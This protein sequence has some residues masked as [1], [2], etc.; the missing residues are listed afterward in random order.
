MVATRSGLG[1]DDAK[2]CMFQDVFEAASSR[3]LPCLALPVTKAARE[4]TRNIFVAR[5]SSSPQKLV[6]NAAC[7]DLLDVHFAR[8]VSLYMFQTRQKPC[9]LHLRYAIS[10]MSSQDVKSVGLAVA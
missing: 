8:Q 1:V 10:N 9:V 3:R 2:R 7:A 5:L 4:S 6:F